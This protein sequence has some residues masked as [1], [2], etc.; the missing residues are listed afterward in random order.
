MIKV[1][2]LACLNTIPDP[3][4]RF[5]SLL[6]SPY[7][8]VTCDDRF[9]CEFLRQ[10]HFSRMLFMPHAIEPE[11]AWKGEQKRIYEVVLLATYI[12]CN[13]YQKKWKEQFPADVC[14]AMNEAIE[15]TFA[16]QHTSFMHAFKVSFDYLMKKPSDSN[17]IDFTEIL[18]DL[19]MYIKGRERQDLLRAILRRTRPC[20]WRRCR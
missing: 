15:M 7:V 14:K 18:Q 8:I 16:D 3:P 13:F 20:I 17:E 5:S 19:E 11:L 9:C 12:D 1:P 10:H 4:Y 6:K 2:H